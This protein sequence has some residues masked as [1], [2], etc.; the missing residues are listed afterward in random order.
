MTRVNQHS[1]LQHRC[2]TPALRSGTGCLISVTE[3]ASGN[4]RICPPR[5]P[6]KSTANAVPSPAGHL[7]STRVSV[8]EN[9]GSERQAKAGKISRNAPQRPDKSKQVSTTARSGIT[10][11]DE[12]DSYHQDE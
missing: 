7:T 5:A 8:D 4:R 1:C 6:S 2:R 10:D 9:A 12:L 11:A 3:T